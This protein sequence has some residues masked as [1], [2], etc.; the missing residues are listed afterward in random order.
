MKFPKMN[1][2]NMQLASNK[3]RNMN[4]G[5]LI[6]ERA[7]L[8]SLSNK[9]KNIEELRADISLSYKILEN[10]LT[11]L[12][13]KNLIEN[14]QGI[15]HIQKANQLCWASNI[16]HQNNVKQELNEICTTMVNDSFAPENIKTEMA[17]NK[18][19][20]TYE[21]ETN[22]LRYLS[23]LESY[24]HEIKEKHQREATKT[25]ICEKRVFLWGYTDYST[26]IH[27]SLKMA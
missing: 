7:I 8:E 27:G 2:A 9:S 12:E 26:L 21:E 23:Q 13:N 16:N 25:K 11:R 15:Y 10:I 19:E 20:M 3:G 14:K 22:F 17:I 4:N 1:L 5:I 18:I 24:L 6:A